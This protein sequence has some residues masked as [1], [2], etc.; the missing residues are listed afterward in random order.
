MP[1]KPENKARYPA[2][3]K[4]RSRFVRFI[5]ARKKLEGMAAGYWW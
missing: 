1:I 3:W 5:R 4:L 2:D